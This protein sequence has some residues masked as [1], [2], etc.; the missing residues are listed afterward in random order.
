MNRFRQIIH[1]QKQL[2]AGLV[3]TIILLLGVSITFLVT[4]PVNP[5]LSGR[6]EVSHNQ[7]HEKIAT[8]PP[9]NSNLPDSVANAVLQDASAQANLPIQ[10]LR[11]VNAKPQDWPDGCLGL[12]DSD[13]FCTQIVVSGWQ[14]MVKGGQQSFVY[15][16]N[17]SGSLVKLAKE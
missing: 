17:D 5:N 9:Q 14:V 16:T 2:F 13:T 10:E 4:K 7:P 6:A 15:R 12:A 11:V 8:Q 3:L 1:Q